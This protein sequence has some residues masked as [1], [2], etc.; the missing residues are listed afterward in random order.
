[1]ANL[2][3]SLSETIKFNDFIMELSTRDVGDDVGRRRSRGAEGPSIVWILGHLAHHRYEMLGVLGREKSDRFAEAFA[4]KAAT[5][6]Q[7]Y[8]TMGELRAAWTELSR[9]VLSALEAATDEELEGRLG[10]DSPHAEKTVLE[11][12]A[13]YVWHEPYHLGQIGTMRSQ[14]GLTPTS[15]LAVEASRAAAEAS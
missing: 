5:D 6:G 7:G 12:L 3:K 2:A 13:F 4:T 11:A 9:E 1:M 10:A 15:T 8:P 14:F